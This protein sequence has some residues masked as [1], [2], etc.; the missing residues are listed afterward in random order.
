MTAPNHGKHPFPFFDFSQNFPNHEPVSEIIYHTK[1]PGKPALSR[2]GIKPDFRYP[3]PVTELRKQF[4]NI[5]R[6]FLD[7]YR[8][9]IGEWRFFKM[10][11]DPIHVLNTHGFHLQTLKNSLT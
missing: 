1:H 6:K 5:I 9:G 10:G 3:A 8:A 11:Q 4:F 7:I 2:T